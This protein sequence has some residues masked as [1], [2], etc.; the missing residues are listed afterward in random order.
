M[1]KESI[2]NCIFLRLGEMNIIK[3]T[4]LKFNDYVLF[5]W[6]EVIKKIENGKIREIITSRN[7]KYLI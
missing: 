5:W 2:S 6:N 4:F 7:F 3:K 1:R